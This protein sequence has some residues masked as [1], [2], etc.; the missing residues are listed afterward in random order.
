M[1]IINVNINESKRCFAILLLG[2]IRVVCS[3]LVGNLIEVEVSMW[4]G[5]EYALQSYI[6]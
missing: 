5:S 4:E 6:H 1:I 2:F 3:R